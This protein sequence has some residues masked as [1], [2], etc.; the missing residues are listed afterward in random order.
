MSPKDRSGLCIVLQTQDETLI[1]RL[2][3]YQLYLKT[4]N[5]QPSVL[6]LVIS[7]DKT[8]S[9][10]NSPCFCFLSRPLLGC[11][12]D[13][14]SLIDCLARVLFKST[15]GSLSTVLTGLGTLLLRAFASSGRRSCD[16]SGETASRSFVGLCSEG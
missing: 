10:H 3:L 16:V 2:N 7:A 9:H 5:A 1:P 14:V 8:R 12:G 15:S 11:G 4:H 13:D 6:L